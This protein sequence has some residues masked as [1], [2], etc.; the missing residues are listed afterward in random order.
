MIAPDIEPI[1]ARYPSGRRD[2]LIP[3][4]QDVQD[5]CGY[6]SRE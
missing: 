3:L 6:L 4:L 2:G 5:A 1:V